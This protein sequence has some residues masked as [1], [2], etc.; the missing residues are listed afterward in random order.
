M[1]KLLL[2]LLVS[3]FLASACWAGP[4]CDAIRARRRGPAEEAVQRSLSDCASCA[5]QR[6]RIGDRLRPVDP[7]PDT[8]ELDEDSPRPM[9]RFL[10]RRNWR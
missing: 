2:S 7:A 4:M 9:R 6:R 8:S 10:F 1:Y 5:I 3:I